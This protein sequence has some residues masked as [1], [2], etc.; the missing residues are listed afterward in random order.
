MESTAKNNKAL[1]R[2]IVALSI[3]IPLAVALLFGIKIEG[4]DLTFL[5]PIYA[6]I[7][8]ITAVVLISA[9]V[10]IKKKKENVHR[11]LMQFAIF[12]SIL[13]LL[14]Y[15][16][17]HITSDST[18][19]GDLNHD[20]ELNTEEMDLVKGSAKYY[21]TLL[22]SHILLSVM[23]IPLVLFAYFHAWQGNF[24]Q[25]KKWTKYAFPIWLYVAVT[26]VIVF[27]MI[28]EYY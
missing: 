19:Y 17:Y 24:E 4:F 5:P 11:K 7:N 20:K 2:L 16:A 28:K 6:T 12:L 3:I 18:M 15:I 21:Y 9:V 10:A 8:G 1:K 25:H 26:G 22:V 27:L 23:V 14:S 13:F